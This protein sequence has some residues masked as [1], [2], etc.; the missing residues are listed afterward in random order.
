VLTRNRGCWP[1]SK[2][3]TK[4]CSTWVSESLEGLVLRTHQ[5]L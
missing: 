2:R 1:G 3:S 5:A 4:P